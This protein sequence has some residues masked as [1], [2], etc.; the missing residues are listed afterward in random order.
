MH[1]RALIAA[2]LATASLLAVA[3]CT[4]PSGAPPTVVVFFTADSAALDANAQ[5]AIKQAAAATLA[6]PAAVAHVRGFAANDTGTTV[7]NKVLSQTRAQAVADALAAAGVA[8]NRIRIE[9]RGATSYE[10][11]PTELRRVEIVVG[12]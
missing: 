5:N 1:R 4:Q 10:L 6:D 2:S 7:F 12:R 8:R 11:V 3:G 9:F